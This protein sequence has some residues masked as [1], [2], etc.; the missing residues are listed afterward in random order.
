MLSEG[1]PDDLR[2]L[3]LVH[4]AVNDALRSQQSI[5]KDDGPDEAS[6]FPDSNSHQF[7]N[8][9]LKITI[10]VSG[11]ILLLILFPGCVVE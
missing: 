6:V 3:E 9:N 10:L 7:S 8:G 5:A 1:N 2:N 11:W 4:R